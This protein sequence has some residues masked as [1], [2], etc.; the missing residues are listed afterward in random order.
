MAHKIIALA[1]R[2]FSVI[3]MFLSMYIVVIIT[4]IN[5]ATRIITFCRYIYI[6][7]QIIQLKIYFGFVYLLFEPQ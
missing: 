4:I 2:L 7:K 5:I 6:L 3:V 1:P